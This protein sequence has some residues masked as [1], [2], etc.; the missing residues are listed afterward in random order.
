MI[1]AAFLMP[2]PPILLKE[3]GQGSELQCPDVLYAL[4]SVGQK[5]AEL[6]PKTIV[7]IT[8]HGP[9]FSDGIVIGYDDMLY[10]NLKKFGYPQVALEKKNNMDLVNKI[11]YESGKID[12]PCLKLDDENADYFQIEKALDHGTIV[13]LKF[14]EPYYQDYRLVQI[15]YGLFDSVKLYEFGKVIQ[16]C[17]TD[18]TVI[19]AS[20]DMSHSLK[21][22]G[23]YR[24]HPSGLIYDEKMAELLEKKDLNSLMFFDGKLQKEAAECGKKSIDIMLGTLDGYQYEATKYAYEGPFGVGY[25]VMGF[26]NLSFTEK[27]HVSALKKHQ[28]TQ[29]E[30]DIKNENRFVAL[31]RRSIEN[32]LGLRDEVMDDTLTPEMLETRAGVFV[33]LKKNGALRGCIGTIGPTEENIALEIVANAIKAGFEDPRFPPL[34]VEELNQLKIS[35]DVLMQPEKVNSKSELDPHKYGVIVSSGYKRGLLLPHLDGIDTVEEQLRIACHKG[36]IDEKSSYQIERFEVV[37]YE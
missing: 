8:P 18:E 13:P 7:V 15:T 37:R 26:E 20:G 36:S 5:I 34:E 33:S 32:F 3:I 22:D 17:L 1:K 14:I 23:P 10:G 16:K 21:E 28:V 19:I 24:Y 31:A 4:N 29:H 6:K 11:I 35:V 25:L 30:M 2:H 12:V 27:S 9:V